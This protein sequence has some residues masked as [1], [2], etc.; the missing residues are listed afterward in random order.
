MKDGLRKV[1]EKHASSVYPNECCGLLVD[2]DGHVA[3]LP[4]RNIAGATD[5]FVLSPEDYARADAIGKITAIVH[6]HPDASP[7]P[8][9]ADRV[10]CEATGLPWHIV[11]VPQM[12]WDYLQPEGYVAPLKGR[13]WCHGVLDCYSLIRDWYKQERNID[14]PDFPRLDDWWHKGENLYVENFARAGFKRLIDQQPEHGDVIL[15]Q[16]LANVPNHGAIFL[17]GNTILHHLYGRL[18]C[19]EVYGGYYRKH[20]THVLRYG[21]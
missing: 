10:A 7:K 2:V 3:Y 13:M 14:L 5:Y 6:S 17:D 8:S 15:M 16:V 20:T 21:G 4:C 12:T 18:S 19:E 1:I 11:S 9:Q